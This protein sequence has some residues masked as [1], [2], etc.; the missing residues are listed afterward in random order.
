MIFMILRYTI[1]RYHPNISHCH[2]NKILRIT[3]LNVVKI[4]PQQHGLVTDFHENLPLI[5]NRKVHFSQ[6][7]TN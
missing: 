3:D 1:P 7:L 2:N 5:S 4:C 6:C